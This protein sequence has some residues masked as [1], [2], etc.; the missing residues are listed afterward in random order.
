[1]QWATP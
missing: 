1:M